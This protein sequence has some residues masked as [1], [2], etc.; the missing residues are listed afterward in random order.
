MLTLVRHGQ[1][2]FGADDYDKLSQRGWDQC[3]RLGEHLAA[4]G[5]R[6]DKVLTGGLRRHRESLAGIVQGHAQASL[7]PEAQVL[8]G[9][10]EYQP[11][12]LIRAIHPEPLRRATSPEEVRQHFRLLREALLAWMSGQTQPE[13][14]PDYAHFS[15]GVAEALAV[16]RQHAAGEVLIVSSG[17]P[18]SVA[19]GQVLSLA[20]AAVV[21]LNL[22]LRNSAV[23]EFSASSQRHGLVS[24]NSLPHLSTPE[25]AS[26][27]TSA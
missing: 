3:R 5:R 24:F 6:F 1:A 20:P 27:I 22:R 21:E 18:I 13:G 14:M 26:W 17:G 19:V 23:T 15:A 25:L 8:P 2:S 9:L 16:A 10:D 11:E 4:H 12:A 7:W